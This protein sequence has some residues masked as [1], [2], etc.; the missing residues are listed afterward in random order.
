MILRPPPNLLRVHRGLLGHS[1][2]DR[3]PPAVPGVD[4]QRISL[5]ASSSRSG[6]A[7]EVSLQPVLDRCEIA[8]L[9]L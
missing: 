4:H 8:R 5:L 2:D 1:M 7:I 3:W 6:L 9:K